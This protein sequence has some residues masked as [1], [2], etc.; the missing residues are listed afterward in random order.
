M[1]GTQTNFDRYLLLAALRY[2]SM[3]TNTKQTAGVSLFL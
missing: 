2:R 3:A 1:E